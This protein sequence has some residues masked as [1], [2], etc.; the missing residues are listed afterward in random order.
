MSNRKISSLTLNEAIDFG[1]YN[2]EYLSQFEEWQTLSP[3][4][5][6]QLIR[7]ALDTRRQ[8]L[9]TQYAELNN[10]LDMSKKPHVQKA[11]KDVEEQ[12]QKVMD[13][14]ERLYIEYSA[15]MV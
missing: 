14:R 5:Q 1:E 9:I 4:I 8:Q 15:G 10:I 3:H 2:P 13:D 7:K 6:W 12:L 11:M